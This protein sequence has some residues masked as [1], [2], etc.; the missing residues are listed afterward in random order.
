MQLLFTHIVQ[1]SQLASARNVCRRFP[2]PYRLHLSARRE[3]GMR[4]SR[5][6]A[7]GSPAM[8]ISAYSAVGFVFSAFIV[9]Y[10]LGL[11]RGMNWRRGPR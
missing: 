6:P 4:A 3:Q 1:I 8:T 2:S 11:L 9:G 10:A 5:L 7:Q